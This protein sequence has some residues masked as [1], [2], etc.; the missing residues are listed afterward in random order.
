MAGQIIVVQNK[1]LLNYSNLALGAIYDHVHAEKL[2]VAHARELI[3]N[4]RVS[5]RSVGSTG[6]CALWVRGVYPDADDR[7]DVEGAD[8][9]S[10]A[11]DLETLPTA[12]PGIATSSQVN[13]IPG[14]IRIGTR[15]TQASATAVSLLISLSITIVV[16]E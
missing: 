11:I 6:G 10:L 3:V 5:A 13:G 15:F 2:N 4:A 9:A 7:G 12:V 14:W 8:L 16:R 1:I